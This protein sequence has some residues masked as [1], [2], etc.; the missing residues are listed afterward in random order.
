MRD[1]GCAATRLA[2]AVHSSQQLC[3][4]HN[5]SVGRL[6]HHPCNHVGRLLPALLHALLMVRSLVSCIFPQQQQVGRTCA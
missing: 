5:S 4:L 3:S 6:S 2:C 1:R